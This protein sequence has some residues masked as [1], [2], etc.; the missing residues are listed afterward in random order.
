[1]LFSPLP[2]QHLFQQ[3]GALTEMVKILKQDFKDLSLL[4]TGLKE[5]AY[6]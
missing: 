6:E 4:E 3:Q 1:M 2:I 5:L